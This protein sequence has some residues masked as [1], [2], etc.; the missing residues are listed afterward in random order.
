M[1]LDLGWWLV[2]SHRPAVLPITGRLDPTRLKPQLESLSDDDRARSVRWRRD[3]NDRY[4]LPRQRHT[5]LT[6]ILIRHAIAVPQRQSR[7]NTP[8][9][10]L[11][12]RLNV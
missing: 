12:I 10:Q 9:G 7:L 2:P 11:N 5:D 3:V 8:R 1:R 4:E 6:E